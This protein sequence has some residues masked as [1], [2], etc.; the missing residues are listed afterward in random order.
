MSPDQLVLISWSVVCFWALGQIWFVQI[1]MYPLFA[2]VGHA[3]YIEFHRSYARRIPLVVIIPGFLS[4]LVPIPLA[5]FGPEVPMWMSV[6]NIVTGLVGL[7]VTVGLAIPRHT[8]LERGGKNERTIA[9]LV[10]YNWPRTLSITAQ[11]AVTFLM[12]RH[13]L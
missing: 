3:D 11:A 6:T 1:V 9:E 5:L 8:R 7:A 12:L 13:G 4:F 2:S 10:R